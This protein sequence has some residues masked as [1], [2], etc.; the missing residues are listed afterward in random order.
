MARETAALR[1]HLAAMYQVRVTSLSELDRGVYRVRCAGD[2]DL[3]ARWFPHARSFDSVAGDADVLA[4]LEVLGFPAERCARPEP[5]LEVDGRPVLVTE[6]I[7]TVPRL[8]RRD[9]IR[10]AGGLKELGSLLG[11]LHECA[12]SPV[13]SRPGGAWHHLA[14]GGPAAEQ[15]AALA[16]LDELDSPAI[17]VAEVRARVAELDVGAGLP[18]AFVHPDFVLANVVAAPDGMVLVD[19]SGAGWGPRVWPLA[20]FLFS[21]GAKDA[22]RLD[23]I[24]A[25]YLTHVA[26]DD[27]E[28]GRLPAIMRSRPA[29]ITAWLLSEGHLTAAAAL[30]RLDDVDPQVSAVADPVQRAFG[31][32]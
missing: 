23:R 3:V 12:S 7:H 15:A 30:R 1:E 28:V 18:E 10:R 2:G 25:G 8:D 5:L 26:L 31:G 9:A 6:W 27:Q 14:E 24:A 17:E 32:G 20:F 19:W 21:E 11:R 16:A 29:C 22:R 13:L 4:A